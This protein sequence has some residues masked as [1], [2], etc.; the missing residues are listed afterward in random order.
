MHGEVSIEQLDELM[1]WFDEGYAIGHDEAHRR[2]G[3]VYVAPPK[4]LPAD[5]FSPEYATRYFDVWKQVSGRDTYD[6]AV[7]ERSVFDPATGALKPFPF[8]TGST[9][10]AA[11]NFD[12]IGKLLDLLDLPKGGEILEMGCGWGN[13]TMAL[14]MLGFKATALDIEERY[15]EVVK[16]RAQ[17]HGVDVD[18]V[19]AE[20]LWVETADRLFDAVIFFGAFHHCLEFQ[21]VMSSLPRVLKP[22]GKVYFAAEPISREETTP[23][24][25]RLDGGALLVARRYGWIELGFRTDF[26]AELLDRS[27]LRGF[28]SPHPNFWVASRKDEPIVIVVPATDQRMQS[29]AGTKANGRLHIR[30]PGA[31]SDRFYGVFGP[32]L[33]LG[34][35]RY[36]A[37]MKIGARE[38]SDTVIIDVCCES[39]NNILASRPCSAA[40][41][42]SGSLSIDFTLVAPGDVEV[43]LLVPGDFVGALEK[44]TLRGIDER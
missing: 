9:K 38:A 12:S 6:P 29:Q 16:L 31:P 5:P 26:F 43:R 42:A 20:F 30:G 2:F 41:I 22:G 17:M 1:K 13:T 25:V 23:W 37:E 28:E 39:G 11:E 33:P 24:S 8:F 40:E 27:G 15:L 7:N 21:R 32:G 14:A 35:G 44:L 34:V 18:V 19:H 3:E 10:L 4:E 36:H